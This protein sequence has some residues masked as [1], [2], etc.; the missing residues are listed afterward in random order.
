MK[1]SHV[2]KMLLVVLVLTLA[3]PVPSYAIALLLPAVQAA[4]ERHGGVRMDIP[5]A[6]ITEMQSAPGDPALV[7]GF[8]G[9]PIDLVPDTPRIIDIELVA[10]SLQGVDPI[11]LGGS[12]FD[13]FVTLDPGFEEPA[14]GSMAILEGS[15][16]T[17]TYDSFFDVFVDLRFVEVGNPLNVL[18][19]QGFDV[20]YFAGNWERKSDVFTMLDPINATGLLEGELAPAA[21]PIP[22]A[23][24]LFGSGLLGLIGIA[25]RK[26]SA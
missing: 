10:L 19:S 3:V 15:D 8:Q 7:I 26:K 9:L 4:R 25:R 23:V 17:L 6:G 22:P 16:D 13:V 14:V 21:I 11:E 24:W 5:G 1:S 2:K 18:K 12:F 20:L